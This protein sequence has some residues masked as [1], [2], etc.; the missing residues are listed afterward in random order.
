MRWR[1]QQRREAKSLIHAKRVQAEA[2]VR[3]GR[4]WAE[5]ECA[6]TGK[7]SDLVVDRQMKV[8]KERANGLDTGEANIEED[9]RRPVE[10]GEADKADGVRLCRA[11]ERSA[12]H[13]CVM[14]LQ[15]IG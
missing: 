10:L 1:K 4:V 2:N 5:E 6:E 12:H 8:S 13:R 15:S 9:H 3:Q 7:T 11:R 14:Q